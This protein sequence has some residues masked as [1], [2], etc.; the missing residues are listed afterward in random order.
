M[1][2]FLKLIETVSSPR[3]DVEIYQESFAVVLWNWGLCYV[4]KMFPIDAAANKR[5]DLPLSPKFGW[6]RV[7]LGGGS[8]FSLRGT[9][10]VAEF[11][12]SA[13]KASSL[14]MCRSCFLSKASG[15]CNILSF[16]FF[17]NPYKLPYHRKI[18][19]CVIIII[20]IIIIKNNFSIVCSKILVDLRQATLLALE[21]EV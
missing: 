17:S 19:K 16:F 6:T 4:Q 1:K 12:Y 15:T 11:L 21:L 7:L 20:I 2:F 13:R 9:A 3:Q 8:P 14:D 10:E 18:H 5:R